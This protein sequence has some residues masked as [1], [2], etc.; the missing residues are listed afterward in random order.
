MDVEATTAMRQAEVGAAKMMP[1]RTAEQFD[2]QPSRLVADAGYGSAEMLGWLVDERGIEP[3]V[4]VFDKSERSDGTFSRGDF[5]YDPE[6]DVYVCPGG[7]ELMTYRR[8]FATPRDGVMKDD[9]IRYRASEF[10]CDACALKPK[11]CPNIPARRIARSFYDAAFDKAR[12]I[13]KT[14]AYA[15]SRRERKKVEMLFA[16]LKRILR[17]ERLRLIPK[18]PRI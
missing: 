13:A 3:H 14:A 16:H 17:L 4:K 11:C 18:A 2:V 15:I 7:K 8:A 9:T 10:D 6:G 1:D 5:A 12:A